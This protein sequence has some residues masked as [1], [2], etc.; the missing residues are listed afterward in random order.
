MKTT[1]NALCALTL[2]SSVWSGCL[3]AQN[4]DLSTDAAVLAELRK[5]ANAR[6]EQRAGGKK[7]RPLEAR[8]VC[9]ERLKESAEVIVI[10]FFAYDRGCRLN[11]AFVRSRYYEEKD[12]DLSQNALATLGWEKAPKREREMLAS[13]WVQKGLLAFFT[14]VQTKDKDLDAKDFHPPRAITE[15]N[16]EVVVT[17]W[18]E[19]PAGMRREKEF[20]RVEYKFAKEG[21]LVVG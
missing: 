5:R 3:T 13:Y 19:L 6:N 7:P 15:Q 16:G 12:A 4:I 8:D 20:K 14:P 18:I 10:G 21:A 11:G 17:L 1:A 2:L 9:I